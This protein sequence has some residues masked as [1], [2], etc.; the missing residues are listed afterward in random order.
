MSGILVPVDFSSGTDSIIEYAASLATTMRRPLILLHVAAPDPDFVGYA[1]GPDTVRKQVAEEF[2]NEHRELESMKERLTGRGIQ[3]EALLIQGPTVEK[4]LSEQ[5]RLGADW[6]VI[7]THGHSAVYD[8][9]VGSI[10]EGV[11]RHTG[12][13]VVVVPCRQPQKSS[14]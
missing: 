9:L 2:R 5:K 14:F 8:L 4:I 6:I 7:G 11:L 3:T 12:C 13:P 10:T 1:A